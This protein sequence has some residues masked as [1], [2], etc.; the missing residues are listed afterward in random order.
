MRVALLILIAAAV[1]VY[2][3]MAFERRGWQEQLAAIG[4]TNDLSPPLQRAFAPGDS[5]DAVPLP[6]PNEVVVSFVGLPSLDD[7]EYCAFRFFQDKWG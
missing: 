5:F 3:C 6:G 7:N 2:S 4:S 1:A